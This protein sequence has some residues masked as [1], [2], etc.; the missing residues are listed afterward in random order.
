MVEQEAVNFEVLGSSPSRGA[1]EKT[2]F[3]W[4][5]YEEQNILDLRN[6]YNSR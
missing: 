4:F 1:H 5:F 6:M 3:G 2:T